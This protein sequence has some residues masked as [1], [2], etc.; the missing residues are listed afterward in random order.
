MG[1]ILIVGDLKP[2]LTA[3]IN[4]ILQPVRD[5]FEENERAKAILKKVKVRRCNDHPSAHAQ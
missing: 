5:H 3:A 2:A 1:Y 4:V